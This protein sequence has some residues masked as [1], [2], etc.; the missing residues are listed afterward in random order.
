MADICT[1][2]RDSTQVV[3]HISVHHSSINITDVYLE[4]KG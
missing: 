1:N 3:L 2:Q 4:T